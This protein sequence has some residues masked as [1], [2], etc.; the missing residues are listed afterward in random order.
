MV[1]IAVGVK[2][3]RTDSHAAEQSLEG[4]CLLV[5]RCHDCFHMSTLKA[6]LA[7]CLLNPAP[8]RIWLTSAPPQYGHWQRQQATWWRDAQQHGLGLHILNTFVEVI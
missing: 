2:E 7:T 6:Q 4:T 3:S 1:E 5:S 8:L